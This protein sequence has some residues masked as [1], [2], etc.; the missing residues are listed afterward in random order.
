MCKIIAVG[1]DIG[2]A[3]I[4]AVKVVRRRDGTTV[5]EDIVREYMPI[6]IK[7]IKGLRE[8]LIEIKRIFKLEDKSY[9]VGVCMTAELSDVF[10]TKEEGV[11]KVVDL[12]EDVFSD[13]SNRLY[14]D[15]NANLVKAGEAKTKPIT[16]AAANWAASAW[17]LERIAC[18]SNIKNILFV[19]IGSTTTTII[20]IVDCRTMVRGRTDPE[21][22]IYGELVYLGTLRT[23]VSSIVSK[24]PFKGYYAN[25]CRERFSLVGDVHLV[26][27]HIKPEDYTTETANGQG[28]TFDEAIARLSRVICADKTMVSV[29]EVK[30]IA[31]YIYE[32]QVFKVFEALMQI[33]SW[34][35]S[36]G[37]NLD[38]F[39]IILAGIGK[40][41]ALEAAKRAGFSKF[42]DVDKVLEKPLAGVVPAYATALLVLNKVVNYYASCSQS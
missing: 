36:L 8:K 14:V 15:F 17:L 37:L 32:A 18:N 4:K 22:L 35:A 1:F 42:I 11:K 3:N 7:G 20:P 31:R 10:S 13:A 27:N 6:W 23:D 24:V 34:L 26:L 39:S 2:G 41:I 29:A 16:I 21:K 38:D 9:F 28:K 12:I 19:D 33:R 25:I 40:H 5:V 30:E